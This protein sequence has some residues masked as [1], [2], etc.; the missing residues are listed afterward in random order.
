M[1][2]RALLCSITGLSPADAIVMERE[3]VLARL[4]FIFQT[5]L[6]CARLD[7]YAPNSKAARDAIWWAGEN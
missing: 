7:R 4:F 6:T 2:A 3:D 5:S 1:S